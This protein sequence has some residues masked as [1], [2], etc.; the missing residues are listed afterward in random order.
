MGNVNE[1]VVL[2]TGASSGIGKAIAERLAR[3]GY[4]VYGTS[5]KQKPLDDKSLEK[6]YGPG[7]FKL[8][9]LD[10]CNEES[11]KNAVEYV[12]EKEGTIDV[13]VNN[14]GFGIAG[15]VEDTSTEEAQKQF[16]TNFFGVHR[17]LR[18]VLPV[19]RK[20]RKGT[21]INISSVAGIFS[22]PFQSVYSASKY[23]LEALSE[24]LRVEVK[25]FGIKVVLVEPGDTRTE[26][27]SRRQIVTA[28]GE[29]SV[30]KESF[31]RSLNTMVRDEINGPEPDVVAKVVIKILRRKNPPVR[32]VVGASYKAMVILKRF[33]PAR[34]VE[35]IIGKLY[36]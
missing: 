9:Q 3:L 32:V 24:A 23:A 2:V 21:I 14:A 16:D 4:R 34:F 20:N 12:L 25:P 11:V 27:T 19:M 36:S 17:M 30:Y 15:S 29:N 28:A 13:L 8:I 35:Y 31:E 18:H 1:D 22:I 33:I 7:F 10:V 5:R 26:F 6:Q